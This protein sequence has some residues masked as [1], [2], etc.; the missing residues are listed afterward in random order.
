VY[1]TRACRRQKPICLSGATSSRRRQY[2]R[3]HITLKLP[4]STM[5]LCGQVYQQMLC[6]N[7]FVVVDDD[8]VCLL[9]DCRFLDWVSMIKLFIRYVVARMCCRCRRLS[10]IQWMFVDG[11]VRLVF[12]F[13][14]S[15]SFVDD[16]FQ[17]SH[18]FQS[19]AMNC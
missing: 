18:F 6:K 2:A 14:C 12:F 10:P 11:F 3:W 16:T 15:S 8:G 7:S 5:I 19:L 9:M 17:H 1:P 13:F 4:L